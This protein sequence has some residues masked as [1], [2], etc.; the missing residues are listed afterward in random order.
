MTKVNQKSL[1]AAVCASF[2]LIAAGCDQP[3]QQSGSVA[4]GT[5]RPTQSA[6]QSPDQQTMERAAD[7]LAAG[8]KELTAKAADA[9]DD[10]KLTAKVKAALIA[11][12]GLK[13]T[14]IEVRTEGAVVTLAGYVDDVM[15]RQQAVQIATGTSGVREVVDHLVVKSA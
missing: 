15:Q 13:A 11:E 1:A 4:P 8:T 3:S 12:P 6:G 2:A 9:I 10:A 14:Q 5:E 7:R